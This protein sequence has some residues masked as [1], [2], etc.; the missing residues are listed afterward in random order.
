MEILM[1]TTMMISGSNHN[2]TLFGTTT[3][4]V[5]KQQRAWIFEWN[6]CNFLFI[7]I[8]MMMP[9]ILS[10]Q[11][12]I[13]AVNAEPMIAASTAGECQ[14]ALEKVTQL[15]RSPDERTSGLGGDVLL[16]SQRSVQWPIQPSILILLLLCNT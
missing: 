9:I 16:S 15:S 7:I 1:K 14:L 13:L 12:N 2:P 6:Q 4:E 3:S 8:I 10:K 11:R 5:E